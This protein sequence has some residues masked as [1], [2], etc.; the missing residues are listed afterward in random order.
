MK[1]VSSAHSGPPM[2]HPTNPYDWAAIG[3]TLAW[4]FGFIPGFL[5]VMATFLTVVWMLIRIYET[6]SFQRYLKWR[7]RK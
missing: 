3:A 2:N 6:S 5:G 1:L 7:S 4:L